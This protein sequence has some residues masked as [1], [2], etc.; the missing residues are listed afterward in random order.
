MNKEVRAN[1]GLGQGEAKA[2]VERA[3]KAVKEGISKAEAEELRARI[4]GAGGTVEL[5]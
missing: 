1:T 3:P 4:E 5:K 2:L